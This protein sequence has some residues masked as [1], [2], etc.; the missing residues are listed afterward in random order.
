MHNGSIS[1]NAGEDQESYSS[2]NQPRVFNLAGSASINGTGGV[3]LNRGPVGGPSGATF[4]SPGSGTTTVT[5]PDFGTYTF[6][7]TA[8]TSNG[9]KWHDDVI[10]MYSEGSAA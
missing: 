10:I 1:V 8:T 2:V 3:T 7:L 6:R 9:F 5:L 4:S